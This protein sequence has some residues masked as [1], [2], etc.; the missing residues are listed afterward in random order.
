M[1]GKVQF[2]NF[3]CELQAVVKCTVTKYMY[4]KVINI[5]LIRIHMYIV[6]ELVVLV[7]TYMHVHVHCIIGALLPQLS[8]FSTLTLVTAYMYMYR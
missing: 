5:R 3:E 7:D 1:Q 6:C 2:S 4:M 8:R